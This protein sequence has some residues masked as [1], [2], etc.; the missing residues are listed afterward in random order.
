MI[1]VV[2]AG[3][4]QVAD[5]KK[6]IGQQEDVGEKHDA[7]DCAN[8]CRGKSSMFNFGKPYDE[9]ECSPTGCRCRCQLGANPDGTC[10]E[11][12]AKDNVLYAYRSLAP[13]KKQYKL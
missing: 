13:G 5:E 2:I 11:A 12:H 8:S 10:D 1:F 3:W 6:C 7:M 9:A 4:V